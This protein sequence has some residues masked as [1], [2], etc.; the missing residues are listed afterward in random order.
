VLG[1]QRQCQTTHDWITDATRGIRTRRAQPRAATISV[2]VWVVLI[3]GFI[4]WDLTSFVAQSPRLP[5][6]SFFIGHVTRYRIGRGLV[7]ALWL[8]VGCYLATAWRTRRR[9]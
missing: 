7:F 5:T 9:T 6:L 2:L 1:R 4:A 8:G 3:G